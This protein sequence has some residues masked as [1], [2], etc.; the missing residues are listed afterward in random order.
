MAA[1]DGRVA[2]LAGMALKAL[3]HQLPQRR[4]LPFALVLTRAAL[5]L[6][7]THLA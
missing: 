5:L 6:L 3:S 4:D 1:A 2:C 7:P